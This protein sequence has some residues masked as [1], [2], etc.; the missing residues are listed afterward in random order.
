M[1]DHF[2]KRY[3][4]VT[5]TGQAT[6]DSNDEYTRKV[7]Y[8][9]TCDCGN[10]KAVHEAALDAG[11]YK[12]CG[13]V[14][15]LS[16]RRKHVGQTYHGMTVAGVKPG[17]ANTTK[18]FLVRCPDC[19]NTFECDARQLKFGNFSHHVCVAPGA[20]SAL[21]EKSR[22]LLNEIENYPLETAPPLILDHL[23]ILITE[24]KRQTALATTSGGGHE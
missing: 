17:D 10:K 14:A 4:N 20:K 22:L 24:V 3:G 7:V 6:Y 18:R 23:D 16:R 21:V 13:C 8:E 2:G 1:K 19:T 5:V 11:Y 12:D 9:I 15:G